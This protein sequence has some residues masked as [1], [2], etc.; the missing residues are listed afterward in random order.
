M[1]KGALDGQVKVPC[2]VRGRCPVWSGEDALDGQVLVL[3]VSLERHPWEGD[4]EPGQVRLILMTGL[5]VRVGIGC[6]EMPD[7]RPKPPGAAT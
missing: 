3:N 2:V 7:T 4:Q 1:L 6:L 5:W